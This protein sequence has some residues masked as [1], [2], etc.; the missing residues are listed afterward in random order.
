M[1]LWAKEAIEELSQC[2]VNLAVVQP[3]Y[4]LYGFWQDDRSKALYERAKPY[5]AAHAVELTWTL[6]AMDYVRHTDTNGRA[7][8]P[9]R[10]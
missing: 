5:L 10:N 1:S 4:E 2:G 8:F 6:V 3:G 9:S 7:G